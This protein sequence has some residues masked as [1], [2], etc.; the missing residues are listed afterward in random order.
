MKSERVIAYIDGFNL[1]HGLRE[2][3]WREY[4]WLNIEKV[5]T[6]LLRPPQVLLKA[7]YYTSRIKGPPDKKRRQTLYI[8]ALGTLDKVQPYYGKY[9]FNDTKCKI[10]HRV[11]KQAEEK[12]TD[13][14]LSVAA[15]NDA[16]NN[17]YDTAFLVTGDVDILPVIETIRGDEKLK[18]KRLV[19]VF[20][21]MRTNDELKR[22]SHGNMHITEHILQQS[23]FPD[24]IPTFGG[25]VLEKPSEWVKAT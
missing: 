3:E 9:Q 14:Q 8:D 21:P 11:F 16:H 17:E 24:Q 4:Y 13:V 12:I 2:K 10:C 22:A 19:T 5:C 7:K 18:N 15:I 1:Y 20:P 23:Q 6:M 25:Y